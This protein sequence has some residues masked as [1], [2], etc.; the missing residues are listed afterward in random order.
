MALRRRNLVASRRRVADEG[1]EEIGSLSAGDDTNSENSLASGEDES[2]SADE[3]NV[4]NVDSFKASGPKSSTAKVD[5]GPKQA[6][7]QSSNKSKRTLVRT[8][9]DPSPSSGQKGLDKSAELDV[10]MDKLH[11]VEDT[12]EDK[13]IELD[14]SGQKQTPGSEK[15]QRPGEKQNHSTQGQTR[16]KKPYT[17]TRR[18]KEGDSFGRPTN[19]GHASLPNRRGNM[20]NAGR[21]GAGRSSAGTGSNFK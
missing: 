6:R 16:E 7:G 20:L 19:S 14:D 12:G 11:V 2:M 1:E 4:S 9:S 3:S 5:P 13:V 15:A 17:S 21:G 10:M 18:P 8:S